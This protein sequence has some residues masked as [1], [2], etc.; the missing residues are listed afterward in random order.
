MLV[1]IS[2]KVLFDKGLYKNLSKDKNDY[3]NVTRLIM[4]SASELEKIRQQYALEVHQIK[5]E[6][7]ENIIC[8]INKTI[9][10]EKEQ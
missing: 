1:N 3:Y 5:Q 2:E 7:K 6:L 10:K 4:D 8:V 9:L